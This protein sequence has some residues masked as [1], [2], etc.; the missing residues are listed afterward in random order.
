[1]GWL[2]GLP[3]AALLAAFASCALVIGVA[4]VAMARLADRLADK[5]G[6]GE[7]MVGGIFLGAS[8]SLSGIVTSVTAAADGY[9]NLAVSNAIGG[10]AAQTA[11]LAIGDLL[12]PR[13]NLEHAAASAVN[14]TQAVLLI[15]LLSVPIVAY[16]GPDTAVFG[17]HPAT[18]LLLG[19][20]LFGL[21]LAASAHRHPMWQPM[22]TDETREDLPDANAAREYS[23][24]GLLLRFAGLAAVIGGTGYTLAKT[25]V[26]IA[27]STGLSK[28]FVGA[29]MTAVATSL[30]ELVTTIAAVR[31][32]ALT[33]AVG[34]IIGGNTF[35]V[36]FLVLADA[37]YRPGSIYHAI[38]PAGVFW[39]A[40]SILM[41]AALVLGMLRREK[42]GVAGIGFESASILAVYI[43]AVVIAA[44]AA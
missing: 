10:I 44:S 27:T 22:K 17:V 18:P 1:M 20:Y 11:F 38:R 9:P 13:A 42:K 40:V 41:T 36:L 43:A 25:G 28:S 30:P 31:S 33:L 3:I 32:G 26:A 39:M 2:D 8:T 12:Y 7:A 5:T 6:L 16:A 35:D 21:R 37:A 19:L 34:G 24:R 23:L 4:G 29:L 14:L 15:G